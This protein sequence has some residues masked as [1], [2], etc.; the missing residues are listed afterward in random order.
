MGEG[1]R[2]CDSAGLYTGVLVD[3][4]HGLVGGHLLVEP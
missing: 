4:V 1:Y 3:V 2:V